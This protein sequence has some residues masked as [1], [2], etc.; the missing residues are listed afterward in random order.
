MALAPSQVTKWLGIDNVGLIQI[1]GIGLIL[2]AGELLY[3]SSRKKL[4]AWR[5]LLASLADFTWVLGSLALV[6]IVPEA[7]SPLGTFAI[8][9]VAG[10]VALFGAIQ[11]WGIVSLFRL[12]E[13]NRYRHC[14]PVEVNVP[15][16]K[17]LGERG[18]S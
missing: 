5:A 13:G 6:A 15:G 9:G 7:F 3:Q 17:R 1:L 10:V 14:V 4:M 12:G 11:I 8:L 18:R 2:F 16:D